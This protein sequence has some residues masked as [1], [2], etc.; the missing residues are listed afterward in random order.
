MYSE[1]QY[2][3]AREVYEETKSVTKRHSV[4]F[5]VNFLSDKNLGNFGVYNAT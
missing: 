3:K 2:R 4:I 1:K 5:C